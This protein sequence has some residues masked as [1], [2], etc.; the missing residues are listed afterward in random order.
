VVVLNMTDHEIP[1]H[2]WING[3]WAP[4]V[5]KANSISTIVI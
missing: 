2:L 5:A 1:Y 4:A 3:Q